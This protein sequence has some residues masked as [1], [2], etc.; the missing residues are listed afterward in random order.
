MK[1]INIVDTSWRDANA[2]QWGE[3]MNTAMMHKIAPVMNRAGYKAIDATAISHFEYAVRY[4]RENPWERMRILSKLIPDT[5]LS[6]MGLGNTLNLFKLTPGPVMGLWMEHMAACGLGRVTLMQCSNDM[7]DMAPGV[8]YAQNAGLE[9]VA[10][11]IYSHSPY[12]TDEYFAQKTEDAVKIRPD[13]VYLKDPGGLLTP[14]RTKSLVHI[15]QERLDGLPLEIHSHCT[16]GLAPLCYLEAMKL[17]VKTF[18][19]AISPLANGPSQPSTEYVLRNARIL[20]YTSSVDEGALEE[21]AAHFKAVAKNE[22]LPI[23]APVEYDLFQ[24]EHQVPG[25][26][27]SNLIRQLA[28]IRSEHSLQEILEDVVLVRKELGYPIMVT[29]FSQ[30]VCTQASL[31]VIQG[32]RYK[33]VTDELIMC[34]LGHYG[35]PPAPVDQNVLDRIHSLPRTK[36]LINWKPAEVSLE[37]IRREVGSGYSEEELLL[38]VLCPEED[39]KVMLAAGP[40]NT[41]YSSLDKPLLQFIKEVA[42]RKDTTFVSVQKEDLSLTLRKNKI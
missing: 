8:R 15:M 41:E 29:P 35:K 18:H 28:Q 10:A 25:G 1:E 23:G 39:L 26:V 34:A 3:K 2:S 32:E 6:Y 24:Y 30:F 20:G 16:T 13:V 5:T 36:E 33:T 14:E 11:V 19:T 22:G 42:K 21:I 17:G 4:L 37:D 40:I 27:I 9:A 38:L 12:H 7:E 31:N